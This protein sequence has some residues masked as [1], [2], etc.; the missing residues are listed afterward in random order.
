[1]R[2]IRLL[3]QYDGGRYLGWQKQT[4]TDNTIQGKL[5]TL[6]CRMC[7]EPVEIHGS[8]R[9]DAGVHALGQVANFHTDSEMSTEEM[10]TYMNRYLPEDIAVIQV[11]EAGDRFH[12]RLNASRKTY[13]Y[14]IDLKKV[15]NVFYRKYAVGVSETLDLQAMRQAAV[16]L[17]G[18]HDFKAFTS[19]KKGKKST[20]RTIH[21]I[22][23]EENAFGE[24]GLVAITYVGDGF[25][26]HMVRILT[27]TLIEV[28]KG[29]RSEKD[30]EA[31]ILGKDR[32]Q[33][34]MLMPAKGL[35]LV[36]VMY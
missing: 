17:C 9:T 16:H 18:T 2:N 4:T 21:S 25:L 23:I 15:P 34:G 35:T 7:G 13:R 29:T 36:K 1:M 26:H 10:L 28:G 31:L 24:P 19:A 12:S 8:G 5:E 27:G 11:T 30:M 3:I 20:V 33:T 6:L 14:L 32:A 22:E